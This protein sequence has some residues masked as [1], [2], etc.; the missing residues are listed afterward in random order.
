MDNLFVTSKEVV[1]YSF[2]SHSSQARKRSGVKP[3]HL[4]VFSLL[5]AGVFFCQNAV[6]AFANDFNSAKKYCLAPVTNLG[7]SGALNNVTVVSYDILAELNFAGDVVRKI[8]SRQNV[9]NEV[10]YFLGLIGNILTERQDNPSAEYRKAI[11]ILSIM[12]DLDIPAS[13]EFLS[14]LTKKRLTATAQTKAESQGVILGSTSA[15]RVDMFRRKLGQ[16]FEAKGLD[17]IELLPQSGSY[18]GRKMVVA[19]QKAWAVAVSGNQGLIVGSDTTIK[20]GKEIVGKIRK[21]ARDDEAIGVLKGR[22]GK[23]MEV[24]SGVVV[25]DTNGGVRVGYGA[26]YQK[27][28]DVNTTRKNRELARLYNVLRDLQ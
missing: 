20:F 28:K 26:A 24:I 15:R 22:C 11:E 27:F 19:F 23:E 1:K 10:D 3:F 9:D 7:A 13:E 6:P 16:N 2:R 21:G 8:K 5:I 25:I 17:G 14:K 18:K 12:F 4:R